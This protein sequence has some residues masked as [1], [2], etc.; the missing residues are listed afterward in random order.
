[1][2][3]AAAESELA[4]PKVA[5]LTATLAEKPLLALR[6]LVDGLLDERTAGLQLGREAGN[7]LVRRRLATE[8]VRALLAY[9]RNAKLVLSAAFSVE[10][11]GRG[12]YG[13]PS[14]RKGLR[15]TLS[16]GPEGV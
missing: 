14:K 9:V 15:P 2:D 11:G 6:A 1:M 13:P 5:V 8:P 7:Q 12:L 4:A 10:A 3:A 16:G